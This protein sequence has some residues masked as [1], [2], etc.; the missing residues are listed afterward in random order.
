MGKN[1]NRGFIDLSNVNPLELTTKHVNKKGEIKGKD[2]KETNLLKGACLHHTISKSGK[3]IKAR[4]DVDG[5]YCTCRMCKEKMRKSFYT[6]NE[7]NEVMVPAKQ[8]VSQLK[9][10]TAAIGADLPT[11]RRVVSIALGLNE[12]PKI[13]KKEREIAEKQEKKGKKKKNK[14]RNTAFGAWQVNR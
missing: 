5:E 8:F 2:K 4:L 6:D 3:K 9:M 1:K 7:I 13:Y 10:M 12:A 11:Q 14:D